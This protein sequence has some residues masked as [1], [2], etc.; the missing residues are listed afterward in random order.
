M[1]EA[2]MNEIWAQQKDISENEQLAIK[3]ICKAVKIKDPRGRMYS[4][5]W[6]IPCVLLHMRSPVTYRMIHDNAISTIPS[7]PAILR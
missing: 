6:I 2:S 4:D 3:E 1:S 5:D 7:V